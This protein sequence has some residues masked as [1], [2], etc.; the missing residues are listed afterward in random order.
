MIMAMLFH[1]LATNAAK[2]GSLSSPTGTV[3]INWSLSGGILELYWRESD[4]PTVTPP[5]HRGFGTRLL[6]QALDQYRGSV[7]TTFEATG[8][9]CKL[10]V[11]LPEDIPH[12]AEESPANKMAEIESTTE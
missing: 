1:E 7:E 12:I 8:V 2:Y 3:S 9:T 11:M 6:S 5:T 10:T 4:G